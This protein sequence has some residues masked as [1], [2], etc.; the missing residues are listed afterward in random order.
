MALS[1]NFITDAIAAQMPAVDPH[2]PAVALGGEAA[3]SWLDLRATE[4]RYA[5]ALQQAGV[6]KGDRVGLLLRNSTDYVA[7]YL[8]IG[9]VG[10]IAVRLNWRLT[11]PELQFA[12][13]DS[14]PGVLVLDA[15]FAALVA[16]IR[17]GVTVG[18]YVVRGEPGALDG[19]TPLS[20]FTA[21]ESDATGFPV[22]SPEDPVSLMYS[23][24]T[25][26]RPKGALFSHGNALWIGS[27]QAQRWR[28]DSSTV[29]QT[30]GPLFHAGGFEVLLLPALL[31]HGTA[32]AFPSGSFTL[33]NFLRVGDQH[34]AT[35]MLLYPFMLF[36]LLRSGEDIT[37]LVPQTLR[38]IV[39]GGDIVMPW[40]YDE[41]DNRLPGVELVQSYSLTEGGAV[42]TSLE[43][44]V[45][46]GHESSIGTPQAMTEIKVIRP[47]GSPTDLDEVGEICVRSGGVSI[48]YWNRPEDNRAT[49][50]DGWCHS[51]DLG[52]VDADG[53]LTIAGRAKDMYRSGGENVYPAEIEMVLTGHADIADA[54]V[55][56]VADERYVEVG[57]ALIVA[58]QGSAID[59]AELRS[60]L[61]EHLAK[62]KVPKHFYFVDEL[63]RNA[64]GKVLKNVLRDTYGQTTTTETNP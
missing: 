11:A 50:V 6:R 27:I 8:A 7:L 12:L 3:L 28:I 29:S 21:E 35:D 25:T 34:N 15:E 31:T 14:V 44:D 19:A 18:T 62:Y 54:A 39:T 41:L 51:G 56:G 22:V 2:R 32:I 52:R 57:A 55:I 20:V 5:R 16:A 13:N 47:D 33:E 59:V 4:L 38:R 61:G 9:R 1:L 30:S 10:A 36:D 17:D 24:G 40:V 53:F 26:G 64:N 49:F 23:S 60:W 48:G 63:P 37:H 58:A 46:R 43:F 45:A 42:S